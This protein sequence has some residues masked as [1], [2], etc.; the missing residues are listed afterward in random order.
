[1]SEP[2]VCAICNAPISPPDF[3]CRAC[4]ERAS[5]QEMLAFQKHSLPEI[6]AGREF[7]ALARIAERWHLV[8]VGDPLHAFCGLKISPQFNRMK[9][10]WGDLPAR[11]CKECLEV[12]EKL[13]KELPA[14]VA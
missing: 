14:E 11:T 8:L 6:I 3:A 9:R 12:F 7:V 1:M 2:L 10:L 5:A 4:T 13:R